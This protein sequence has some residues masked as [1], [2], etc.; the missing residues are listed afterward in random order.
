MTE[1]QR[2]ACHGIIHTHAAGASAVAAGLA[3][4]PGID[5][6]PLS[7][8]EVAMAIELA[9]VFGIT[10]DKSMASAALSGVIGT[11]VGRT[12]SQILVGWIPGIGN[13][14]NGATAAAVVESIGWALAKKFEAQS[15]C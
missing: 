13:A 12:V 10:L 1:K 11:A 6:A 5:N 2:K 14:I 4:L 15:E 8:I 3:Q 9:A 7:A